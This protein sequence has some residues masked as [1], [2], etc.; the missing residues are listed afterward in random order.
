MSGHMRSFVGMPSSRRLL[1]EITAIEDF[2]VD[3]F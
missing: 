1:L 2:G 3:E